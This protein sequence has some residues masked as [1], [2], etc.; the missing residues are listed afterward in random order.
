MNLME[1]IMLS[2]EA[3]VANKMRAFLTMIGIVVGVTAVVTIV[4]IGEAGK[5]SVVS[6]ISKYGDGF[7]TLLPSSGTD[8][9]YNIAPD[10]G[11]LEQVRKVPRVEMA[12]GTLTILADAKT[13]RSRETKSLII[14]GTTN[15]LSKIEKMTMLAG[16]FFSS[17]EERSRQKVI[18]V[19][20]DYANLVF[21]SPQAAIGAKL[22]IGSSL[23]QIIGVTK[24]ERNLFSPPVKTEYQ[25]YMSI[26]VLPRSNDNGTVTFSALY[27]K[28]DT[29]EEEALQ[30]IMTD[31]KKTVAKRH[32]TTDKTYSTQTAAEVEQNVSSVFSILQ[33]IIGSIAGISLFV[34]G[35]GVMNI[36]LVSVTERTRE[37]GI[38]K[39]LGATPGT[40]MG[41]FLVEAVFLCLLGGT[42]GAG[43]GLLASYI[44]A[45][46]SGWPYSV[47]IGAIVLAFGFSA[48]VG[49]FFGIY[50]ARKAAR[51][52]PIDALRYE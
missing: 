31:V 17:A 27:V 37:I 11:D 49:L 40:I 9:Q 24:T 34:G 25:A 3:L 36:M 15:E 16:R 47:S 32:N 13:E 23:Y 7:F 4:S 10:M 12:T 19:E 35:V 51:M 28:A 39:A 30:K 41:Q 52:Q 38:R 50:P 33:V 6:S 43:F 21:G 22:T 44:F 2:M 42:A 45:L 48:G 46:V 26:Y 29:K 18:V 8:V 5:T 1:N 20:S 14:S